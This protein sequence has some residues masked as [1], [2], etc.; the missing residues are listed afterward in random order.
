MSI[1]SSSRFVFSPGEGEDPNKFH[2]NHQSFYQLSQIEQIAN[3]RLANIISQVGVNS[4]TFVVLST[5]FEV[6]HLSIWF[7]VALCCSL[8][9]W[10]TL[11]DCSPYSKQFNGKRWLRRNELSS[12]LVALS[13]GCVPLF[14]FFPADQ[15]YLIFIICIYTGYTAGALSVTIGNPKNF[16][17]FSLGLSLPFLIRLSIEG[18]MQD[19]LIAFLIAT[20]VILLNFVVFN[21]QK[22][23][24]KSTLRNYENHL[25]TQKLAREKEAVERAV[26]AKDRFLAAASHDLRQ[27]LNAISLFTDALKPLQTKELGSSI[28]SKVDK[29]LNA[30][31]AM[32]H[33]LLDVSKLDADA[34]DNQPETLDVHIIVKQLLEEYTE[35]AP[36]LT[37]SSELRSGTLIEADKTIFYRVIRNLIDNAIKYTNHG[38]VKVTSNVDEEHTLIRV[39]DSGIGIPADMLE[40]VF[41]EFEQIGNEN[42][43]REKG[44][45]LG[46]SIVKRLCAIANFKIDLESTVGQGTTV[47]LYVP[48]ISSG[49]SIDDG[50]NSN[51]EQPLQALDVV[52]I[53]DD[54]DIRAGM[55]QVLSN[56]GCSVKAYGNAE[57]LQSSL[58]SYPKPPDCI[59]SDLRLS[60]DKNGLELI[61]YIREEFN[62]E[63]PS[64][65]VT[66]DTSPERIRLAQEHNTQVLYK[67][68]K[69]VELKE[70]LIDSSK[71]VEQDSNNI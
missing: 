57:E 33:S 23:F 39:S 32:L 61:E 31:N 44:L 45:G 30:L 25:L 59:I 64:L 15:N 47:S 10:Y 42:R 62:R 7:A 16:L 5:W 56:W 28:L 17:Y 53:D 54:A 71:T 12:F 22:I 43:D 2:Q 49:Q 68:V 26:K 67:P 66:G 3:H 63:I 9:D 35:K 1:L 11:S 69:P 48:T 21:I 27:P 18:S 65:L 4:I 8:F 46:L 29:S 34:I 52:I 24:Y 19:Y 36:H 6:T 50:E 14:F 51:Q 58:V 70:F 41:N 40:R 38:F 13:W 55:T 37:L 20:F 60:G